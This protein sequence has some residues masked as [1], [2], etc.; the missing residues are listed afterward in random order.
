VSGAV[1][2]LP[3][4]D[5]GHHPRQLPAAK[6]DLERLKAGVVRLSHPQLLQVSGALRALRG[7]PCLHTEAIARRHAQFSDSM[8][9]G[10]THEAWQAA[11]NRL[12]SRCNQL[13]GDFQSSAYGGV[14]VAYIYPTS[15]SSL[16]VHEG[17]TPKY[18]HLSRTVP[19]CRTMAANRGGY[20]AA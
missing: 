14:K 13:Y 19:T 16:A 20:C 4:D 1:S 5:V 3:L 17:Y 11:S 18:Q 15:S 8:G 6:L 7:K 10:G 2:R 12:I 9:N